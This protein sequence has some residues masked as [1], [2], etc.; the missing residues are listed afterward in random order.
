MLFT[1][2]LDESGVDLAQNIKINPGEEPSDRGS[3]RRSRKRK[4]QDTQPPRRFAAERL[5]RPRAEQLAD[6]V[7]HGA[8]REPHAGHRSTLAADHGTD[9]RVGRGRP[10]LHHAH[11]TGIEDLATARQTD[12]QRRQNDEKFTSARRFSIT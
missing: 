6:H 3:S 4:Q 8:G 1:G 5:A 2:S 11:G 12:A 10:R 9:F 7:P